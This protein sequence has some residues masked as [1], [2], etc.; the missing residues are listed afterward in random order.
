MNFTEENIRKLFGNEDALQESEDRF[1]NYFYYNRAYENIANDLP[2]RIIVGH[3]GM[4]KSALIKRSQIND[5]DKKILAILIRPDDISN[6]ETKQPRDFNE[7]VKFWKDGLLKVIR[8][9]IIES[10]KGNSQQED[11]P[12]HGSA[13]LQ[14]AIAFADEI[15][16]SVNNRALET[17]ADQFIM[18]GKIKIYI[19]DVD[20][21]WRAS[22]EDVQNISALINAVKDISAEES[23]MM[24]RVAL[25]TD[26]YFLVRTSDESMDKV[27]GDIVW[28][29]WSLHEILCITAK[30]I[31]TFFEIPVDQRQ[32][33][34]MEPKD[35]S[36]NILS[37]IMDPKF[38][39]RGKWSNLPIHKVIIS[40]VRCRPRDMVKLLT[41]AARN[42]QQDDSQIIH[43]GHFSNY[44]RQYSEER[45]RDIVNE[46]RSELP[47]LE[48][49]LLMMKPTKKEIN[50]GGAYLYSTDE[51]TKKIKNKKY[52]YSV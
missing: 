32:L 31:S 17:L 44:F 36:Q 24:F 49:L 41:G 2:L 29:D 12:M 11:I 1:K 25:R 33:I 40:L 23:K 48:K 10:F 26:V 30:R 7:R 39:G 3:K 4:G 28:I 42:A 5:K 37:K 21:G 22:L 47:D 14:W 38:S 45:L 20:R 15:K 6:L 8:N 19:D 13:L 9:K 52:P 18:S 51:L 35:I 27:E 16:P 46:F 34:K 50:S 43:S